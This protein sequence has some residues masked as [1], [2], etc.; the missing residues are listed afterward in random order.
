MLSSRSRSIDRDIKEF[1]AMKN[2]AHFTYENECFTQFLNDI[3]Q[4]TG[5][6]RFPVS[7]RSE[8]DKSFDNFSDIK[9]SG[10]AKVI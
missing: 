3:T 4:R 10:M 1:F 8:I 6:N 5:N 7:D 2:H 9:A